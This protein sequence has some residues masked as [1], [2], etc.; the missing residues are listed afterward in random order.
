MTK[1]N[2]T[3]FERYFGT[4]EA[5]AKT[6]EVGFTSVNGARMVAVDHEGRRVAVMKE[7]YYDLWLRQPAEQPKGGCAGKKER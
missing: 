7:R 5:K 3:N 4:P 2:E 6:K 1:T